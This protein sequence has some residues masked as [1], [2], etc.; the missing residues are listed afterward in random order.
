MYAYVC[1]YVAE[2]VD[3]YMLFFIYT[4]KSLYL[5]LML[6]KS[7]MFFD[8]SDAWVLDPLLLDC[9]R[10]DFSDLHCSLFW[11]N[12]TTQFSP[13]DFQDVEASLSFIC[14]ASGFRFLL[15]MTASTVVLRA[16]CPRF[17]KLAF[18]SH[19]VTLLHCFL[20]ND[21]QSELKPASQ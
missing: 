13:W 14:E 1:V 3:V 17:P 8:C 20:A 2:G 5:G 16:A 18:I 4:L 10:I 11:L 21:D 15:K 12:R 19:A 9:I 6:R 7:R